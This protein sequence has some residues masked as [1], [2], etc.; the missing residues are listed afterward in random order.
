M[1]LGNL[2]QE[3]PEVAA[4][5]VPIGIVRSAGDGKFI[6]SYGSC[7]ASFLSGSRSRASTM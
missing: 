4:L 1:V 7:R 6:S 5:A 3:L 2:G